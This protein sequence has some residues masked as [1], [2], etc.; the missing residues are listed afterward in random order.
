MTKRRARVTRRKSLMRL[1]PR[2]RRRLLRVKLKPE[3]MPRLPRMH[4]KRRQRPYLL[5]TKKWAWVSQLLTQ[6]LSPLAEVHQ[7]RVRLPP[8]QGERLLHPLLRRQLTMRRKK[9]PSLPA[10]VRRQ[11]RHLLV[12]LRLQ[13]PRGE[14][15]PPRRQLTMRTR[16]RTPHY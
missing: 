12:E 9:R 8:S 1:L 15:P 5:L 7:Q 4:L 2:R 16:K 11:Q 13:P 3:K 6:R 10:D 14:L